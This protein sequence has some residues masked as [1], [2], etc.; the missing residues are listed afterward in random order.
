MTVKKRVYMLINFTYFIT[1]YSNLRFYKNY[2]FSI[3][4][5]CLFCVCHLLIKK[6]MKNLELKEYCL[7]WGKRILYITWSLLFLDLIAY[8]LI[9]QLFS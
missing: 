3:I 4:I 1:F 9:D 6:F 7:W 8:P 2:I 5:S